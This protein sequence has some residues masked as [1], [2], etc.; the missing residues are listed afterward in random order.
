M[1]MPAAATAPPDPADYAAMAAFINRPEGHEILQLGDANENGFYRS[2]YV[3]GPCTMDQQC[4]KLVIQKQLVDTLKLYNAATS[5]LSHT[6]G[7]I[8][9]ASLQCTVSLTVALDVADKTAIMSRPIW[10]CTLY[11]FSNQR[12]H[13]TIQN[14]LERALQT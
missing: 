3:L 6:S 14:I 12:N 9:N 10:F 13:V 11:L 7:S 1:Y 8:L 5:S 2:F 4:G